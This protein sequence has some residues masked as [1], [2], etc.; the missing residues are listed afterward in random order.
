MSTLHS[1]EGCSSWL[2]LVFSD[3]SIPSTR[4]VATHPSNDLSLKTCILDA[5]DV[6]VLIWE[7]SYLLIVFHNKHTFTYTPRAVP[8]SSYRDGKRGAE[9]GRFKTAE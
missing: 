2:L 5:F 8:P 1:Q 9:A 7:S 3:I 6:P 4:L